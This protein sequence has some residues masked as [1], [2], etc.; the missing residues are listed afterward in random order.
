M[1]EYEVSGGPLP[2]RVRGAFLGLALGDAY[3][4]PLEFISS[5]DVRTRP[6]AIREGS[7]N[8]TDDTH[9]AM[10]LA[11]AI[12]DVT[13]NP[14]ND[15]AFGD[16]VAKRFV[17]WKQ[18]MGRLKF[19]T[20]PGG[21]CLAG[22]RKYQETQDWKTSG[23]K[24]SDGCG[25]VMRI[26]PLAFVYSGEVLTKAAEVSALVTHGHPNAREAA[27]AG[28]HILRWTLEEGALNAAMVEEAVRQLR[29]S[30][31]RGGLVADLLEKALEFTRIPNPEWL[32][33]NLICEP[34]SRGS[35][36][37]GWRSG[38]ALALA[39]AAALEWGKDFVTA[40]D[41]AARIY[42]DSDSVACLTG[43][44]LGAAGGEGILPDEWLRCIPERDVIVGLC[45]QL[46]AL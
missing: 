11:R 43:M 16:A 21:T 38:S 29:S 7:F 30:W 24:D 22:V 33:E 37:S 23:V 9:M 14:F 1:T 28:S 35:G 25:A 5:R 12:L 36:G 39:V 41:K 45:D 19:G 10:F 26:C 46:L 8:W 31:N 6:V 27:I 4:A 32:D 2:G 17:E 20:A 40:V 18:D 15:E 34:G 3:G 13:P 44:Y 42:G